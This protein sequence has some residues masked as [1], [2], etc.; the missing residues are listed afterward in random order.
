[1]FNRGD[2]LFFAASDAQAVMTPMLHVL[3][4]Y[5]V[6][7]YQTGPASWTGQSPPSTWGL[8][9]KSNVYAVSSP[10]GLTVE[11]QTLA[12]LDFSI[13]IVLFYILFLFCLPAALVIALLAYNDFTQRQTAVLFSIRQS[14]AHKLVAPPYGFAPF[15]AH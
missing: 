12:H 5:G 1:V 14:V 15:A 7:P 2:R 6:V 9:L 3:S 4:A 11:V 10:H 8:A 13:G